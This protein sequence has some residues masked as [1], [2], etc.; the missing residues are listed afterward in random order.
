MFIAE[1]IIGAATAITVGALWLANRID[2]REHEAEKRTDEPP[3]PAAR[4]LTRDEWRNVYNEA[5]GFMNRL[6]ASSPAHRLAMQRRD[7]AAAALLITAGAD[8]PT[9]DAK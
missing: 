5:V 7:E 3:A 1:A 8:E 9:K 6:P 4:K 2:E